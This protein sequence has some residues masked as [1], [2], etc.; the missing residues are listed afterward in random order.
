MHDRTFGKY[1]HTHKDKI[2]VTHIATARE[3]HPRFTEFK[4][5]STKD[6]GVSDLEG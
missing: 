6:T 4:N 5:E 1:K 3:S 2:K